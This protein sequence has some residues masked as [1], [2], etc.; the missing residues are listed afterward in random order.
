MHSHPDIVRKSLTT[1]LIGQKNVERVEV[2]EIRL[3]PGQATGLHF[4]P[5]PVVG[6]IAAGAIR[7]QIE[8][9]PERILRAGEA[10]F[11]PANV[12]VAHFDAT[13]EGP[14]TFIAFYLLGEGESKLIEML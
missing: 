9:Q 5:C 1:A 6:Y 10:F 8:G 3:V 12:R 14:A 7:F 13:P 4:H 2:K 11:E